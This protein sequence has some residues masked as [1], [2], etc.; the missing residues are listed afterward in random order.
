MKKRFCVMSMLLWVVF[1]IGSLL[2][3]NTS[4][5]AAS[6]SAAK[7]DPNKKYVFKLGHTGAPDHH[8][9]VGSLKFAELVA[10]KT[11]GKV[12]IKVFPADQLGKQRQLVEG[13][14]LGT[15][16]MVLTSDVL[17]SSFVPVVGVLNLP[18]LF[19]DTKQVGDVLDG[20]VGKKIDDAVAKKGLIV[21]GWWENGFRHITNSRKPI[22][23]PADLQGLK[24]RTPEGNVFIET[25]NSYGAGATPMSFG[26]LYSALQL[27]TV[28][29][30]E[31]PTSHV[32]SQKYYEVQKYLSLTYHIHVAEPL[33]MSAK[34]YKTLPTEYQK[35]LLEAGKEVTVWMRKEVNSMEAKEIAELKIKGMKVNK[36]DIKAFKE[37]SKK[38]YAKFEPIFGKE[39][40][41]EITSAK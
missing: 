9:Q 8:Y 19:K 31:N 23:T 40:I 26:E 28:D 22:K 14:Q 6:E 13:C 5:A 38:I 15:V 29:G 12:E 34:I 2:V 39:L 36:A 16:D 20:P 17:L 3:V 35:A 41:A 7:L 4:L 10:K 11:N 21:I 27:G 32:L 25:F 37:A 24:I 30:Q 18:F 33:L 1:F